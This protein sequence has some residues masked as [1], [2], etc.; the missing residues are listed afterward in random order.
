MKQIQ[1]NDG[2]VSNKG[3]LKT[4]KQILI[5][6]FNKLCVYSVMNTDDDILFKAGL[7]NAERVAVRTRGMNIVNR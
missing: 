5:D 1:N 6:A 3:N 4:D 2:S 7:N